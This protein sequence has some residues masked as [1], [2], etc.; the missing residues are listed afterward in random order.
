MSDL[1]NVER[2]PERDSSGRWL[3]GITPAGAKPWVK[4]QAPSPQPRV[5]P[6]HYSE[7]Q[8][9]ARE[10]TPEAAVILRDIARDPTEDTPSRIVAIRILMDR[11]WGKPADYN[12]AK[13]KPPLQ[14]DPADY[15]QAELAQI[16]MALRI[17]QD[18]RDRKV[19]LPEIYPPDRGD[20]KPFGATDER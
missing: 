20:E 17:M 7:M 13:D 2:R 8:R 18:V 1:G 5:K 12:P 6:S 19:A 15:T 16:E 11:A 14:F 3:P 4:G 9:L 10:F